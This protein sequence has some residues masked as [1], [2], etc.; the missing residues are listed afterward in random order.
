M[1][2]QE[3]AMDM[4]LRRID[5]AEQWMA[6]LREG[7]M[8]EGTL[9]RWLQW[10]ADARNLQEFERLQQIWS[11]VGQL[12]ADAWGASR[13]RRGAGRAHLRL[14]L[15]ASLLLVVGAGAWLAWNAIGD[16]NMRT[17][18]TAVAVTSDIPLSDGSRVQ[19]GPVSTISAQLTEATRLVSLDAGEAYFDVARD[20]QRPFI[21][22]AGEV[23][24]TAIGTAFN[25]HKG[26]GHVRVTVTEGAIRVNAPGNAAAEAKAGQQVEYALAERQLSVSSTDTAVATAWRSGVLK[27]VDE[28]LRNVVADLN[29]YSERGIV[30]EDAGLE[31]L[32]YTGT[33]FTGRI[34]QWL[35]ALEDAF[36]LYVED[37]GRARVRLKMK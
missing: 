19:L 28:P 25:V 27:F 7:A 34:D 10:S 22:A 20:P 4:D 18:G 13:E 37:S 30:I 26:S 23:R 14:A 15:A 8:D 3:A 33:V 32:P 12:G 36:P 17:Y 24:V 35:V 5:E 6:T 29:R 11:G 9:A 1:N 21:V 16:P 2:T 31:A